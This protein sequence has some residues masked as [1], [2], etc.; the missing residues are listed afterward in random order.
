MA[1]IPSNLLIASNGEPDYGQMIR[2]WRK[3][4]LGWRNAGIIVDL[5]NELQEHHLFRSSP[6]VARLGADLLRIQHPELFAS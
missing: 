4:I 1:H 3:H 2:H 6:D 5:Y